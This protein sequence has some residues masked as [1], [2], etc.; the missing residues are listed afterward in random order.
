MEIQIRAV[1]NR[2]DL[3]TYI[4]LPEKIHQNHKNWLHPIYSDEW[5]FYSPKNK[6]YS[7]SD[8]ILFLA[9]DGGRPVG[10]VMGIV[11]R[12]Y[13]EANNVNQARFCFLE[14]ENNRAISKALLQKVEE[15][16][17]SKGMAEMVGPFGFS[18]KEPQGLLIE[19]FDEPTVIV[20]NHSFAYLKDFVELEGYLPKLDLVQYKVR[21]PDVMPEIYKRASER[22]A[23]NGYIVKEFTK[24]SEVRP[25][26]HPVFHLI[27]Q[28]YTHIFGFAAFDEKEMDF[29]ANRYIYL[30]DPR[31]I[32]V[33]VNPQNEPLG[34]VIAMPD[35]SDGIRKAKG[36]LFPFGIIK[37]LQSR[38]HTLQLNLLLG[39]IKPEFRHKGLDTLMAIKMLESAKELG[40]EVID[41]HLIME[42]NRPMRAEMERLS[43]KIYK[44]YRVYQ[45][46]L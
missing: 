32:K 42:E 17:R 25:Y 22:S 31:L 12:K 38:K 16:A 40:L 3:R 33:V 5:T 13:N 15:W 11:N 39:A 27:N 10:R 37:I 4:Y 6:V 14:C 8:T 7:Y 43:A 46:K 1:K 30:L 34:F 45:K 20:T 26:I 24:R 35:I 28:T 2:R 41:S 18:D 23:K 19:G 44:R 9:Y 29:F 21:V 36:R